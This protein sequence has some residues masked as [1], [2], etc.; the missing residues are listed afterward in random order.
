MIGWAAHFRAS[1]LGAWRSAGLPAPDTGLPQRPLPSRGGPAA[2]HAASGAADPLDPALV[3]AVT[4]FGRLFGSSCIELLGG[5]RDPDAIERRVAWCGDFNLGISLFDYLCDVA[6]DARAAAALPALRG[7][8]VGQGDALNLDSGSAPA[9]ALDAVIGRA[10]TDLQAASDRR[11]VAALRRTLRS[12]YA[13]ELAAASAQSGVSPWRQDRDWLHLMR[14]K[15]VEPFRVMAE[16]ATRAHGRAGDLRR[17]AAARRIGRALGHCVW[18]V[19]DAQDLWQDIDS[20]Q[21]NLFALMANGAIGP[22]MS[23]HDG[24][25]ARIASKL[26]RDRV[27]ERLAGLAVR[28]V[29]AALQAAGVVRARRERALAPLATVLARW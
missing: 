19:D 1:F 25:D 23:R 11:H 15:S 5:V 13:A 8:G 20:G 4:G 28:R 24:N 18:L 10:L 16:W 6:G 21:P 22:G 17:R 3:G 12:M 9:C 29:V 27:A 7:L 14:L 26:M 2:R